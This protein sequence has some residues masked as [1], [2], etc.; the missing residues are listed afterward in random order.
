M[1]CFNNRYFVIDQQIARHFVQYSES[2]SKPPFTSMQLE[3]STL[4]LIQG[5]QSI[6]LKDRN[7]ANRKILIL[8]NVPLMQNLFCFNNKNFQ[9]IRRQQK[10]SLK[11]MSIKNCSL[12]FFGS[13]KKGKVI[14]PIIFSNKN[15][16]YAACTPES[17][18]TNISHHLSDYTITFV[19]PQHQNKNS[20]GYFVLKKTVLKVRFKNIWYKI[21][22]TQTWYDIFN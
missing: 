15:H 22:P 10:N 5:Y 14:G 2:I 19:N 12:Y 4:F 3:S 13:A 11:F 17:F 1:H 20:K 6:T 7:F 21:N 9:T 16:F 8:L 18:N